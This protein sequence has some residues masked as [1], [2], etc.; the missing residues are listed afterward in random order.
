MNTFITIVVG[1]G[2]LLLMLAV[3]PRL[4]MALRTARMKG[5]EAPVP[6]KSSEGR[7]RSGKKTILYFYTPSCGA[8]RMQEASIERVRQKYPDAIYKIDASKNRDAASAYGVLGVPFLAFIHEGKIVT[9]KAGVQS[10]S[11]LTDFLA[12]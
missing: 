5:K 12:S 4:L 10:E 3:I 7:I 2:G 6:H 9:A 11:V 8:C 1:I